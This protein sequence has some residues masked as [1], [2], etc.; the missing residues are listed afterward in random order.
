M[1]RRA[2]GASHAC[3]D[4]D[5]AVVVGGRRD[6]AF[7]TALSAIALSAQRPYWLERY[8]ISLRA[9][10]VYEDEGDALLAAI[11]GDMEVIWQRA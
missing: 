2:R 8:G 4:L 7:E 6:P 11:G 9:V 3:S 10:A 5:V 1:S